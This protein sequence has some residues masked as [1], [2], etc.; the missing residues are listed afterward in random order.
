MR[1]HL[2]G[3]GLATTTGKV[4]GKKPTADKVKVYEEKEKLLLN[5]L[6]QK[7]HEMVKALELRRGGEGRLNKILKSQLREVQ[8]E[9]GYQV[10]PQSCRVVD[11][12]DGEHL[13]DINLNWYL[14][15]EAKEAF[16]EHM[17]TWE[18]KS[19]DEAELAKQMM[20]RYHK[21]KC[22][23]GDFSLGDWRDMDKMGLSPEH[24]QPQLTV[25]GRV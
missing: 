3:L 19:R 13:S 18:F 25:R 1:K 22:V 17:S 14:D 21:H 7:S 6:S 4:G 11:Y 12:V 10:N 9:Q 8:K 5:K 20:I 23:L 16:E 15:S 24:N 2:K